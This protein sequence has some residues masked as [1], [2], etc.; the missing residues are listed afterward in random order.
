VSIAGLKIAT[1]FPSIPVTTIGGIPSLGVELESFEK[2]AAWEP[3]T[4][5]G[6]ERMVGEKIGVPILAPLLWD[7]G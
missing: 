6:L 3:E 7:L 2:L 4:R 1:E 5:R